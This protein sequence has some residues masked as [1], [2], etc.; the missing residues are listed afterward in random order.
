MPPRIAALPMS[1]RGYPVP[2]FVAWVDGKP[3]FR[4]ADHRKLVRA[5]KEKL[6]YVCGQRLGAHKCFPVG[7]M[8]TVNRVSSE[9]PSH[10]S[11]CEWSVK[12]C[13]FL[14]NPGM[15]R[16]EKGLPEEIEP[17]AGVSIP[18]NPGVV[19]LW[20]VSSYNVVTVSNGILFDFGAPEFVE[21]YCQGREATRAEVI[22]SI[23][24]GLPALLNVCADQAEIDELRHKEAVAMEYL[25]RE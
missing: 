15:V 8:C 17:P 22:A 24:S 6:C 9:P 4:A 2:F 13:P 25:P 5:V 23:Q 14:L 12:A 7:P 11:C 16:R 1:E 3:E 10:L 18:R 19:A 20:V 21:W